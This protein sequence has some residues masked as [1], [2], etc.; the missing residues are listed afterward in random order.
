MKEVSDDMYS[1]YFSVFF[2]WYFFRPIDITLLRRWAA[3][4]S[5]ISFFSVSY[6]LVLPGIWLMCLSVLFWNILGAPTITGMVVVLR[7]HL[8]FN[9]IFFSLCEFFTPAFTGGLSRESQSKQVFSSS[10]CPSQFS[11]RSQQC[12]NQNGLDSYTY[13]QFFKSPFQAFR[14]HS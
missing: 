1:M 13:F 6:R 11:S 8:F 10:T 5:E 14:D 9:I 7:C 2:E 4:Q 12:Y 3:P